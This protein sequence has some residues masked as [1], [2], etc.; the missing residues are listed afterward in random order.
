MAKMRGA[1][2]VN[3]EACKGCEVCVSACPTQVIA[4]SKELNGKGY[5]VAYMDK[6]EACTGCSNCAMVCP[7]TV[8]TVY[9]AKAS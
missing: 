9:R 8:I 4:M 5:H 2:V 3:E 1:I 6:P 7:D